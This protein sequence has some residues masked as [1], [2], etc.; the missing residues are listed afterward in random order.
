MLLKII[1]N[2]R[3]LQC[4]DL[5]LLIQKF[6][7]IGEVV[8][9]QSKKSINQTEVHQLTAKRTIIFILTIFQSRLRFY[10]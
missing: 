3:K 6:L 4:Y 10:G 8:A 7:R 5:I 9:S 2:E 1:P